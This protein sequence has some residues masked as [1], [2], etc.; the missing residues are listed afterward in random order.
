MLLNVDEAIVVFGLHAYFGGGVLFDVVKIYFFL[1]LPLIHYD[2]V[3][4]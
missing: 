3:Y 4:Q 1:H 2:Q